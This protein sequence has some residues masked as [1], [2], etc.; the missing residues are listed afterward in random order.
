MEE[1]T[2]TTLI[3]FLKEHYLNEEDLINLQDF[4]ESY[5]QLE[6]ARLRSAFSSGRLEQLKGSDTTGKDYVNNKYKIYDMKQ[7]KT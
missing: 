7:I 4:F 5:Q 2:T 1:L 3:N 6:I